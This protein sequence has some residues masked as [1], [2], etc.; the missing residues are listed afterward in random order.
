M[1][2]AAAAASASPEQTHITRRRQ[3]ALTWPHPLPPP[4]LMIALNYD[5][6][7]TCADKKKWAVES[8]DCSSSSGSGALA[9][10]NSGLNSPSSVLPLMSVFAHHLPR[11]TTEEEEGEGAADKLLC[12]QWW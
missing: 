10:P 6:R 1:R 12:D 5:R 11:D 2:A 9:F 3:G 4:P 8:K 7:Q